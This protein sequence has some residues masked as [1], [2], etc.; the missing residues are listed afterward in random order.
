MHLY[1][2]A[3]VDY[4]E[5]QIKADK[6]V[7]YLDSN[8]VHAF[9]KKDSLGHTIEKVSLKDGEQTITA[10]E[11]HYNYETKKGKIVQIYT[12]EG[13]LHLHALKAK[14]MPNDN[15]FVRKGKITT[16][17]HEDPHFYFE[18]SKL[19]VIPGKVMVAGPTHLV[20][21]DF[22]TPIWVPF[23][24]FPNNAEKQ[25]GIIIPS[26][27]SFQGQ[28]GISDFG[29]HWAV[30]DYVHLEFLASMY[31]GGSYQ[32]TGTAQ[33]VKKYKFNGNFGLKHNNTIS[34]VKGTSEHSIVKDYNLTWNH[35]Q[36]GKAHPN[37]NFSAGISAKTQTYNQTQLLNQSNATS[38]VEGANSS[39]MRWDWREK[40]GTIA[41]NSR[42]DQNFTTKQLSLKAP[43]LTVNV[44]NQKLYKDFQVSGTFSAENSITAADSVFATDWQNLMKNGAKASATFDLGSNLVI[45]LPV[46]KYFKF[47]YPNLTVNG[48]LNSK[49]ITKTIAGDTLQE[50]V[51]K[52]LKPSYDLRI[53]N[54]GVNTKIYGM[55][56]FKEGMYINAFRHTITPS[57]SLTWTPDF[58]LDN[59]DIT[60]TYFDSETGKEIQYSIYENRNHSI[61]TPTGTESLNLGYGLRN[62]L[63]AKIKDNKDSTQAYKKVN[64]INDFGIAGSYNFLAEE[65]KFSDVRLNLNTNPG[66]LRNLN[67][68]ATISPYVL[69]S[70]GKEVDSLLW[71]ENKIGRLTAASASTVLSLKKSQ[72][73]TA[74]SGEPTGRVFDWTMDLNYTFSYSNP[75]FA[76]AATNN[77]I[78]VSGMVNLTSNW[79][80]NYNLPFNLKAREISTVASLNITRKLHCWEMLVTWFPFQTTGRANYT[81]TIRPTSSIL[82]DLKYEK[83]ASQESLF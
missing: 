55:F 7:I 10:P 20:I 5:M 42:F 37:S 26:Q 38:F 80:V 54:F 67:L 56:K 63:Q 21:R 36:D 32:L 39:Q 75:G 77:S 19:K 66:F 17:D 23:G 52:E 68:T 35:T 51:V 11:I 78:G 18:A 12:Q 81:L 14:K 43:T 72:F 4:G 79:R 44:R 82:A 47:S 76:D 61:Y 70:A 8:Q 40:W 33:Y 30:N 49:Y 22:H 41:L 53:G 9:G 34:G 73:V 15:I 2:N 57:A 29:Y 83:K 27:S 59:Q 74:K 64:I 48:Y 62:N 50:S 3:V 16:C 13:E 25:S 1:G 31:F 6:I 60:R 24:I 71:N 45:K 69:D 58:F 46:L 28:T 65:F